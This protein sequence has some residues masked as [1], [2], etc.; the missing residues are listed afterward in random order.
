MS[1]SGGAHSRKVPGCRSKHTPGAVPSPGQKLHTPLGHPTTTPGLNQSRMEKLKV[2]V[3]EGKWDNAPSCLVTLRFRTLFLHPE[4]ERSLVAT[5][6]NKNLNRPSAPMRLAARSAYTGSFRLGPAMS[7][8]PAVPTQGP[9]RRHMEASL[10]ELK[11]SPRMVP[12][13]V[14]LPN[15]DRKGFYKRK[16]V[17][18]P[19]PRPIP[20]PTQFRG[21]LKWHLPGNF[22]C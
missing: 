18:S 9:C 7:L 11:A 5:N 19:C 17:R 6:W 10:Q 4:E 20:A 16:Q 2:G 12:R 21:L 8:I 1:S 15:C 13:A 14:Y 22:Y 3:A